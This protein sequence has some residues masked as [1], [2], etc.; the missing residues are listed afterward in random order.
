MIEQGV[1]N[2]LLGTPVAAGARP[3]GS[4]RSTY[5]AA[6][7]AV[8][9]TAVYPAKMSQGK[10][11]PYATVAK[12]G[13]Q[14]TKA[15]QGVAGLAKTSVVV[16]IYHPIYGTAE[17]I[18]E[19]ARKLLDGYRGALANGLSCQAIFQ[20]DDSNDWLQPA[21]ADEQGVVAAELRFSVHHNEN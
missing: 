13:A 9:G 21:H 17:A 8:L 18:A 3:D 6:V 19:A 20:D 1:I 10:T 7:V 2:L 4:L 15:L 5:Q 12:S 14:H 11:P 16:R